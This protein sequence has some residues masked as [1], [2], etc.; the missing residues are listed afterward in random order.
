VTDQEASLRGHLRQMDERLVE[1]A[2]SLAVFLVYDRPGRV[3]DRPGLERVFF[4]QRCVS[5]AQLEQTVSAFRSVGAYVELFD[6]EQPFIEALASGRLQDLDRDV[7]VVYNGIEGGIASDGFQAGRKSLLPAVADSYGIICAN[8]NAYAC[9]IGR[10]K[11][12][13]LT[14]LQALGLHTP[15]AWH[16]RENY[17]WA[18]GRKPP[19][20]TKVIAKSTYESWSV[21]VTEESIFV[22]DDSSEDR[23]A[24]IAREIGQPVTVQEF[25]VGTEVCVPILANPDPFV[26]PPV[27]AIMS[28]APG[29]PEAVMT[30]EDNLTT[31]GV[32][33]QPF[34]S[35]EEVMAQIR[36]EAL[37]AFD[38]LQLG[39]FARIDFRVGS[40]ERA[41]L[42]D[43]GVSPGVGL[44]SSAFKS[45]S[46]LDFSHE[47]FLRIVLTATLAS[48]RLF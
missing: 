35:G 14:L 28:K 13:Y 4:A 37:A 3:T 43:V 31:G 23:V 34:F 7:K 47:Q 39:A 17:G 5:D 9:A 16:Y 24:G 36:D 33:H 48:H 41:W 30:I 20:G 8:S 38:L 12:H 18:A 10:H 19:P 42:I 45:I 1:V 15:T 21:G 46:T 22:V 11:F 40:D 27:Q 44:K 26:T 32:S 25:I 2:P 29:D 6:G